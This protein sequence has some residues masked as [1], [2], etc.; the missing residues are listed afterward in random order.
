MYLVRPRSSRPVRCADL[1]LFAVTL[2]A[3]PFIY[4]VIQ[5]ISA[6]VATA[7][8]VVV[9]SKDRSLSRRLRLR[10]PPIN[11]KDVEANASQQAHTHCDCQHE[12]ERMA[13]LRTCA[14]GPCAS[15]SRCLRSVACNS[16]LH[17][18]C[19]SRHRRHSWGQHK[20]RRWLCSA[21]WCLRNNLSAGADTHTGQR[22]LWQR[23]NRLPL[24]QSHGRLSVRTNVN[25]H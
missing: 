19:S 22:S 11:N 14:V 1:Q 10:L 18:R 16:T 20:R 24:K 5:A 9:L 21:D 2:M 13:A 4:V 25:C 7:P 23:D 6:T 3:A 12:A 15:S 8:S 17:C